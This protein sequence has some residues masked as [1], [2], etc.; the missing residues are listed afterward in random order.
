M[1]DWPRYRAYVSD[2]NDPRSWTW[3][4]TFN[5]PAFGDAAQMVAHRLADQI[6]GS[7]SD[8]AR[9][10]AFLETRDRQLR[11]QPEDDA[12]ATVWF[13]GFRFTVTKA[14]FFTSNFSAVETNDLI[15]ASSP[16]DVG[17]NRSVA[18]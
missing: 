11:I 3:D 16:S 9:V 7:S 18:S 12:T 17:E 4:E 8:P 14:S 6:V 15:L 5:H 2:S 13:A 10:V 1:A